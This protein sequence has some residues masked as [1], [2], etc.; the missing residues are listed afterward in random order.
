MALRKAQHRF[1]EVPKANIQRS[2]FRRPS[3][4]KTAFDAG[5]LIPI[6]VDEYY[7][8]DT[9]KLNTSVFARLQA[10]KYPILDN[11]Y[12]DIHFF[13]CPMRLLWTNWPKFMGE[14]SPD[15]D[16]STDYTVPVLSSGSSITEST[17]FDYMGIPPGT[18]SNVVSLPFRGYNLI[19]RDWYRDQNLIDSPVDRTISDGP[20]STGHF[21]LQKRAKHHDYFTSA[22]PWVSKAD[23]NVTLSLGDSA[24]VITSADRQVTGAQQ[25]LTLYKSSDGS[26]P[27]SDQGLS[28]DADSTLDVGHISSIAGT[29]GG[30]YPGNLMVDLSTATA[31]T[32]NS[33]RQAFAIQKLLERDARGGT[34]Y[35]EIVKAH[36]NVSSPDLR[37]VRPEF[38]GG[39]TANINVNPVANTSADGT[40]LQ[41]ELTAFALAARSG[42]GFTKSFTEHGYVIGIASCRADQTYQQGARRIFYRNT[43]YDFYWPALATIGEQAILNREIYHQNTSADTDV[44]GYIPRYDE[45]RHYPSQ[46]SGR[47]RSTYGTPLDH[48]HLAIKYTSLPTLAKTFIEEAPP[49]GRV[50]AITTEKDIFADFYFDLTCARPMPMFGVPGLIDHF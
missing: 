4:H 43:K 16:S 5:Y 10:L 23:E 11:L 38:L 25:D 18:H 47:M 35:I 3:I 13:A 1:S 36:F 26:A 48:T 39:G 20:D 50:L 41:G 32:I 42:I 30:L 8:G 14:R 7:P 33:L 15:P 49:M 46:I 19:Y 37:A 34:R 24:A 21:P 40:N 31:A 17:V 12:I 45:L 29:D 44:F 27:T 28:V 22:L 2:M 9:F 6:F